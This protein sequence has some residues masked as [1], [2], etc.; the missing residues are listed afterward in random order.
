M[1]GSKE[2][3]AKLEQWI[4]YVNNRAFA[5]V[6]LFIVILVAY[7]PEQAHS[8]LTTADFEMDGYEELT[9]IS[10]LQPTMS[11]WILKQYK[12]AI[13]SWLSV[14]PKTRV[15]LMMAPEYDFTHKF[16]SFF[17]KYFDTDRIQFCKTVPNTIYG[18]PY[19]KDALMKGILLTRTRN[20]CFIE[21]NVA[22]DK[23]WYLKVKQLIGQLRGRAMYITGQRVDVTTPDDFDMTRK[24]TMH[25]LAQNLAEN[26]T[27][28]EQSGNDYFVASIDQLPFY[29]DDFPNLVLNGQFW[30]LHMNSIAKAKGYAITLAMSAPVYRLQ[31]PH[32]DMWKERIYHNAKVVKRLGL[33]LLG[34]DEL[35]E[36]SDVMYF[37]DMEIV[38][39]QI[40]V[41]PVI[42]TPKCNGTDESV[43][44]VKL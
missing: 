11:K 40:H 31:I 21:S 3:Q 2:I 7:V 4:S 12:I 27:C 37:S 39:E 18:M 44:D 8:V 32:T 22:V 28:F 1:L 23:L 16:T 36:Q 35:Q 33:P 42:A 17:G 5:Y 10:Y 41:K 9:F 20:F 24:P 15:V 43:H 25:R 6:A 14:N 29:L 19:V 13:T 38:L 34:V 26:A 30:D